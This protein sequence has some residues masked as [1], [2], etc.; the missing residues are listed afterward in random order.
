MLGVKGE[1]KSLTSGAFDFID[2]VFSVCKKSEGVH[3]SLYALD[4][5]FERC[6][7]LLVTCCDQKEVEHLFPLQSHGVFWSF[8][9]SVADQC[10]R[11]MH[12]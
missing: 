6:F 11:T 10:R 1:N 3:G 12:V 2:F 7:F 9:L 4:G 5:V 8:S